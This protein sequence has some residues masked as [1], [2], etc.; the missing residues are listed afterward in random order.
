MFSLELIGYIAGF[1][2]TIAYIPQLVHILKTR[3]VKDISLYTYGLLV[4]GI[5]L[6]T[7]YG[8]LLDAAPV[9]YTNALAFGMAFW[10][11]ALK[12]RDV[13]ASRTFF[14]KS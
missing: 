10:I 5:G 9:I 14:K 6:W 8:I 2:T 4:I 13:W 7:L 12:V 11:F 3:S 1:C